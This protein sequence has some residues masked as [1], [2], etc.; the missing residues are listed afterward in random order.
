MS[1]KKLT[2]RFYEEDL[3]LL[4]QAFPGGP[5]QLGTQAVIRE[6]I[7]DWTNRKLRNFPEFPSQVEDVEV[8]LP[9]EAKL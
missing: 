6:I 2:V 1:L 4:R 5:G 9:K 8:R 7:H 3:E